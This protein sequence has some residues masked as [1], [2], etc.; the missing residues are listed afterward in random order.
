M[1]VLGISLRLVAGGALVAV[2]TGACSGSAENDRAASP[3]ASAPVVR[4]D[5]EPIARRF[6]ALGDFRQVHWL[7][8]VVGG[9][10]SGRG[11][12]PGPSTYWIHA[13]VVPDEAGYRRI[14]SRFT[15]NEAPRPEADAKL[16]GKAD[17]SGEWATSSEFWAEL[18]A[19]GYNGTAYL[20]RTHRFVYLT[21]TID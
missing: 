8:G 2:L 12:V 16:A 5:R 6:P 3:T 13:V 7:G 14:T 1:R 4:T 9:A 19:P 10:S 18:A 17:F 21:V 15:W 11:S 20:N